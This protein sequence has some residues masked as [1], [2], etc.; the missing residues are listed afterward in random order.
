MEKG[1]CNICAHSARTL[2]SFEDEVEKIILKPDIG[3]AKKGDL[4]GFRVHKFSH[5][6]QKFLIAYQFQAEDIVFFKIGPHENFYRELKKY[7][8]EVEV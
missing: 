3:E 7:L 4:S 5:K 6:K 1:Y 8:R 2:C